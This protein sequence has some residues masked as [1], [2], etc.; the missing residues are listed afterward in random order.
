MY[1]GA[2]T[3]SGARTGRLA[4]AFAIVVGSALA[5]GSS[6]GAATTWAPGDAA[7]VEAVSVTE[8]G[9]R[10]GVTVS[11]PAPNGDY[12]GF[13]LRRNGTVVATVDAATLTATDDAP[14]AGP[15]SYTV[16]ATRSG[17]IDGQLQPATVR[18]PWFAPTG[19]VLECNLLWTGAASQSW[20]DERNW[21]PFG[22]VGSEGV[23]RPPGTSDRVCVDHQAKLPI[24]VTEPNANALAF[25]GTQP[26]PATLRI[27]DGDLT[28]TQPSIIPTIEL[29]GGQLDLKA[30]TRLVDVD[31]PVLVLGGGH[32][33]IGERVFGAPSFTSPIVAGGV[34]VL[35]GTASI[36]DGGRLDAVSLDL[37][38]TSSSSIEG[39]NGHLASIAD[40]VTLNGGATLVAGAGGATLYTQD[41]TATGGT[42]RVEWELAGLSAS[43][44]LDVNVEAGEAR[45]T[46]LLELDAT[47]EGKE[48]WD[49]RANIAGTLVID[50]EIERIGFVELRGNGQLRPGGTSDNLGGIIEANSLTLD[51]TPP[52]LLDRDFR[53]AQIRL[54]GGSELTV[55]GALESYMAFEMNSA[56]LRDGRL[57]VGAGWNTEW[58]SAVNIVGAPGKPFVVDGD[59]TFDGSVDTSYFELPGEEEYN[60][61]AYGA[62]FT[63]DVT[64]GV[65]SVWSLS[66]T[67]DPDDQP[68]VAIEGDLAV[69]GT[70]VV[71]VPPGVPDTFERRLVAA[72]DRNFD[73][74]E[75]VLDGEGSDEV[76][77]EERPDG[78]WAVRGATA[79]GAWASGAIPLVTSMT[80]DGAGTPVSVGVQWPDPVIDFEGFQLRRGEDVVA[81]ALGPDARSAVDPS[82][83][84]GPAVYTVVG[85]TGGLPGPTISSSPVVFPADPT[86]TLVWSGAVSNEWGVA[87]NW[88]PIGLAGSEGD[89]R[90]PS[91]DEHACVPQPERTY[92]S[93]F[94]ESAI[95]DRITGVGADLDVSGRAVIARG[96]TVRSLSVEGE[97]GDVSV[98]TLAAGQVDVSAGAS[99]TA[100]SLTLTDSASVPL[101]SM[102][103]ATVT[104]DE[105]MVIPANGVAF[106]EDEV[107]VNGSLDVAGT[108][109]LG[110]ENEQG[111]VNVSVSGDLRLR[112]DAIVNIM[113]LVSDELPAYPPFVAVGGELALAG[114]LLVDLAVELPDPFEWQLF[115]ADP[116]PVSGEFDAIEFTGA[117]EGVAVEVVADGVVLRRGDGA[118]GEWGPG[119]VPQVRGLTVGGDGTPL[120]ATFTWPDPIVPFSRFELRRNGVWAANGGPEVRQLTDSSLV[121]A[122]AVYTVVGINL[123][124]SESAIATA[125][126]VF[127][128]DVSCSIVW[129]GSVDDSWSDV[130]NWAPMGMAS[131]GGD[132]RMPSVSDHVCVPQQARV[133]V[134]DVP[135]VAG[136]VSGP[137]AELSVA[138]AGL[139]VGDVTVRSLEVAGGTVSTGALTANEI[140]VVLDGRLGAGAV[141]LV[142]DAPRLAVTDGEVGSSATIVV[143]D[144]QVLLDG[145][146]TVTA[147]LELA[148]TS[149]LGVGGGD[150]AASIGFERDLV[151]SA[152]GSAVF[153]VDPARAPVVFV[154]GEATLAGVLVVDVV[155]ELPDPF[156]WPLIV[157]ESPPLLGGF[158]D[159]ELTGV[160]RGRSGGVPPRGSG[161]AAWVAAV[162][163]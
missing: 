133:F 20:H 88:T 86:C 156:E 69:T 37:D 27:V 107:T 6:A 49:F 134:A 137:D 98:D 64:F 158:S 42:N 45:L 136:R 36:L 55:S 91:L 79:A 38:H 10:K 141:S 61:P 44:T 117:T 51:A 152:N 128:T 5:V 1:Q 7:Q 139:T 23:P 132:V 110:L 48:L 159:V 144:G 84:P 62:T 105:T 66:V 43:S 78:I 90:V 18:F 106:L 92:I 154:E 26:G 25:T 22:I 138:D 111:G 31:S 39:R 40:Q 131:L 147:S 34:E 103:E 113:A 9:Q 52:M 109:A 124:G 12:D 162:G 81:A 114:N 157:A 35:A 46:D 101:L 65:D 160:V 8:D 155:E 87:D 108:L 146:S 53:A 3:S 125:P 104:V 140:S 76:Q 95:A 127:P 102:G 71:R 75:I 149:I 13:Q 17:A 121:A 161:A 60:E 151:L 145:R 24:E 2:R 120:S 74:I 148:G 19:A 68:D 150:V 4:L 119:V 77:I 70:V 32:L 58:S 153:A 123:D 129:V 50:E 56:E 80:V 82:P 89:V 163:G 94:A 57:T 118:P 96:V 72:S 100:D 97:G 30:E 63:G 29:L 99:L 112:T 130:R 47:P 93:I 11:W 28:L 126:V 122:P 21:A 73:P 15:S 83:L 115:L 85:L 143:T 14:V 54:D 142:G 116:G 135:A 59:A 67:T 33:V 16:V 41:L